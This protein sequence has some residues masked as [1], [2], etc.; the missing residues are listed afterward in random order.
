MAVS[1]NAVQTDA[2]YTM[3]RTKEEAER[4]ILQS[5]LYERVTRRFFEEAGIGRGMRVLDVGSGSGDVA[6]ASAEL[7]GSDWEV[8]GVDMNG[9]I[10]ETARARAKEA[11]FANVTFIEGDARTLDLAGQFDAVTGRLVLMYMSDP[12]DALRELAARLRRGGIV[13]FQ[14]LDFT[15][16]RSLT[17]PDT[18]LMDKIIDWVIE[19]FRCSGAHTEMGRDLYRTF[20]DAG[21]PEPV[22]GWTA[23]MGGP[24][25][26]SGYEYVASSLR[27][28]LPL[29]EEYG[30]ATSEEVDVETLAARVR[31]EVVAAKRPVIL[32]PHVTAWAR[33]PT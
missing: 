20:V 27:S 11:G 14:E 3:G 13:A 7:V 29:I 19:V 8:V 24:A 1:G 25:S 9:E 15:P 12:A 22:L 28:L 30:I 16:Y 18:P 10:L 6:F 32:P 17:H 5:Q 33:V 4:L 21:L 2:T 31:Q 26:W 23:P